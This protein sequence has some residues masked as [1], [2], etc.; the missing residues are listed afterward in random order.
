MAGIEDEIYAEDSTIENE[1]VVGIGAE[2]L[3]QLLQRTW[4]GRNRRAAAGGHRR[5]QGAKRAKLIKRLRV[6][7][8]SSPPEPSPVDGAGCDR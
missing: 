4:A 7:G 1:P 3:K 5:Q 6:I 2:A 8:A